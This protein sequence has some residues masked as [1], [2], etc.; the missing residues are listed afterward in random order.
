MNASH[1]NENIRYLPWQR[2]SA[3][4]CGIRYVL[5]LLFFI[6]NISFA[7]QPSMDPI[8]VG[9]Q[10]GHL[11]QA[12]SPQEALRTAINNDC[13]VNPSPLLPPGTYCYVYE[14][15]TPITKSANWAGYY[16][17]LAGTSFNPNGTIWQYSTGAYPILTCPKGYN[18]NLDYG[19]IFNYTCYLQAGAPDARK[20]AGRPPCPTCGTNPINPGIGNKYQLEVDYV[21]TGS[22]PLRFERSYNSIQTPN[23]VLGPNWHSNY[24]RRVSVSANPAITDISVIRPDGKVY[25]FS[26]SGNNFIP[27]ADVS[28]RLNR[29]TDANGNFIGWRYIESDGDLTE[30]YGTDGKLLSITNRA[31]IAQTMS[32]S[33][34]TGAGPNGGLVAGTSIAF[35]TGLLLRVT[36]SFG[37]Q[38]QFTYDVD[39]RIATMTDPAGGIYHYTYGSNKNVQS[40]TYPD[41]STRSYVYN[42]QALTQNTNLPNALT[43]IIDENNVRFATW[44]YDGQGRAVSSEHAGGVEKVTL[45]YTVDAY[46]N[47]NSITTATDVLGT[48]RT[49][50]FK[51]I[52]GAVKNTSVSGPCY[53]CG[54]SAATTYDANGNV[55]SRTD[56]NGNVTTYQYDLTRNLETSRVEASGTPQA[57]TISTQWHPTYRLPVAIAEPLRLTTYSYDGSGNLLSK[58]IQA[59][60]DSNGS[61]GFNAPPVGTPRTWSY[62]YNQ[63]GQVLT[64]K[65]PR[66]DVNDTTSYAYD[67]TT[68]NLLTITNAAGQVTMLSNYDA[69]GRVGTITDPNGLTT[70]LSYSPRGWLLSKSVSAA[71]G[72]TQTTSY[73]YD[74]V[75][76]LTQVT[77]PDNSIITYT[78]DPAHRLTNIAD[79]LGNSIAYTLDAM[80]NRV[81][82][83]TKDPT[84]TLSRQ[85]TRIYDALN[86]LQQVTGAVQ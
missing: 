62:T 58:T 68:G 5:M 59:T 21:G 71:S 67:P 79:S 64:A 26:P 20:T 81:S 3:K 40:V 34:G 63:Y 30:I 50:N 61:Q 31:G 22:F 47:Q 37:R 70:N 10:A 46:T 60:T 57:R 72:G 54:S 55:A 38:L 6:S 80:G 25:A 27:D 69:N 45:A 84:G 77:L 4:G 73:Q 33:D 24:E 48:T 65:G 14:Y 8:V 9:Y 1:N 75:G 16:T 56:F 28:G 13:Y 78:Y 12:L 39:N 49:Y 17:Y 66:T 51:N 85:V 44:A 11:I 52:L 76:Q 41:G 35:N 15:A 83:Q 19:S 23:Q 18:L 7:S 32:Y 29:L 36:D 82:E 43:G 42:E 53:G 2:T 74:G 86:R